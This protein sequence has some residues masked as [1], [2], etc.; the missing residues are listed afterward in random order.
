MWPATG[1]SRRN[2]PYQDT[3]RRAHGRGAAPALGFLLFATAC[4]SA[5]AVIRLVGFDQQPPA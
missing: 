4:L 1:Y 5:I 3:P 2:R